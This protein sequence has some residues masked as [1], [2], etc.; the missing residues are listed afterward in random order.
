MRK[1]KVRLSALTVAFCAMLAF[2]LLGVVARA[3]EDYT[4]SLTVNAT[5]STDAS[6][7]AE[8][9]R[10]DVVLDVYKLADAVYDAK[11]DTY[12]YDNWA[13]GFEEVQVDFDAI[14]EASSHLDQRASGTD[15]QTLY[16]KAAAVVSDGSI[17]PDY[18]GVEFTDGQ[19]KTAITEKGLYLVMA[20]G[21]EEDRGTNFAYSDRYKFTFPATMVSVPTKW[22]DETGDMS[23][24]IYTDWVYGDWRD[25]A[26]LNLK[27]SWEPLFGRLIIDKAVENFG[28]EETTFVF[29]VR[30][31]ATGTVGLG[32]LYD[33]YASITLDGTATGSTE[34]THIPAQLAV[35]IEETYAGGRYQYVSTEWITDNII[36]SDHDVDNGKGYETEAQ[37][38]EVLVNNKRGGDNPGG[39]HG[40]ENHF[41]YEDASGNWPIDMRP[42]KPHT[43]T[44]E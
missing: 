28:G 2:G 23:A 40:V 17:A 19:A 7:V 22:A 4:F 1:M 15:W 18:E 25:S 21:A 37:Y 12:S 26:T 34:L 42:K 43:A 32:E 39:G 14:Q 11:F 27:S 38:A 44:T 3:D 33:E 41:T 10:A 9:K 29:R 5:A 30:N 13:A 31:V 16:D 20:R 36:L 6:F 24:D 8:V 35:Q